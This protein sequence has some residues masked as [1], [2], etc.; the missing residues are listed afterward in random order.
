MSIAKVPGPSPKCD[1]CGKPCS[2]MF[3]LPEE[4]H[5]CG[6]CLQRM[7]EDDPTTYPTHLTPNTAKHDE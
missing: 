4:R 7:S 5:L 1:R 6:D 2:I 3:E